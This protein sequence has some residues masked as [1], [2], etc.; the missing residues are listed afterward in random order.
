MQKYALKTLIT[1]K[2][3]EMFYD[4]SLPEKNVQIHD[5]PCSILS[6]L[7]FITIRNTILYVCIQL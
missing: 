1:Y 3:C 5:S 4:V 6:I 7:L 2:H